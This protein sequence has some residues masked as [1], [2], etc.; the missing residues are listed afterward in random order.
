MRFKDI[1]KIAVATKHI[2]VRAD[3]DV[4]LDSSGKILDAT[5]LE[6][7]K[8]TMQYLLDHGAKVIVLGHLGRPEGKQQISNSHPSADG[9]IPDK[10]KAFSLEPVAEW[11]AQA[12][13]GEVQETSLGEFPGWKIRE[14]LFVI[15][16]VRFYQGEKENNDTFAQ[17]LATLGDIYVNDAFA[18][19][20]RTHA[21]VVAI[22][23]FLP[24][25]AGIHLQE[26]VATLSDIMEDPKRPLVVLIGGAK[27]ETKLPLIEKMHHL[28][29]FVLVG[30]KLASETQA[31][32][33]VQ[34]EQMVPSVTG[35]K[36]I[37]LVADLNQSGT[38]ITRTSLENF[39]QVIS[40]A[41]TIVW[42]GPVGK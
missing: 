24:S 4:P 1:R 21:S 13:G 30:G 8:K 26:E 32:L 42:N 37:L 5:R 28:A 9:Q 19:A 25:A 7:G 2:V 10:D 29:D 40:D 18:V 34:H 3:L 35:H 16:N 6:K 20:H 12:F 22:T 36:S 17:K 27:I 23:K 41:K 39:L 38:D 11:L 33:K 31:L 15:E 14:N